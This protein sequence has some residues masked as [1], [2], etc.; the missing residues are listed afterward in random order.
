M[1]SLG[2]TSFGFW[3]LSVNENE[4]WR[5]CWCGVFECACFTQC[6]VRSRAE[7]QAHCHCVELWLILVA[8]AIIYEWLQSIGVGYSIPKFKELGITTPAQLMAITFEDFE[9]GN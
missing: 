7:S 1:E 4:E 6:S 2:R 9:K 3:S 8:M 5:R